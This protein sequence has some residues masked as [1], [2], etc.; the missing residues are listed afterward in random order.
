MKFDSIYLSPQFL[1][2]V[3]AVTI[4]H[5]VSGD[6]V[7]ELCELSFKDSNKVY[8]Y[9]LVSPLRKFPHGILSEDG[10]Y[11]VAA[12]GTVLWFQLCGS[13]IFNH[14]PPVCVD[15]KEC[16]CTVFVAQVIFHKQ[17]PDCGGPTRCG[18][19][20][21]ALVSNKVEGYPV[22]TTI[23]QPSST[24]IDVRDRKSPHTGVIVKMTHTG[25]K[26]NCSLSVSVICNSNGVEGP[27]TLE[28]VGFCDYNTEL[29]HP[30]GCPKIISS[31][32][33]GLGWFG[34]FMIIILCLLGAY[35][36]AGAVYRYFFLH[37]RGID[38]IPN[39]EFW[40]SLPHRIQIGI[41]TFILPPSVP[42]F[43]PFFS[44]EIQRTFTR[45]QE[46]VFSSQLLSCS[47]HITVTTNL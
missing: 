11:K 39:L 31:H 15:C 34:S 30:L 29:K 37:I 14:D 33:N 38:V 40:A 3:I 21:S 19:G 23:G 12:N 35:L 43:L 46:L 25:S 44:A 2:L 13:M 42:E 36:L 16:S 20:C 45:L 4:L 22:C 8:H 10:F 5:R 18:M 27:Q 7:S 17:N 24:I 9:S 32:G 47:V 41:F 6:S 1:V 26:R 28:T